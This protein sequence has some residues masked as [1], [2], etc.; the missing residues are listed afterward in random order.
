MDVKELQEWLEELKAVQLGLQQELDKL[1]KVDLS[2][3]ICNNDILVLIK[4]NPVYINN[5]LSGWDTIRLEC[6]RCQLRLMG[7]SK[8]DV[9]R[10]WALMN[11]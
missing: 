10:R 6:V 7:K 4:D 11:E 5:K 1:S 3:P 8:E 9:E 2:C